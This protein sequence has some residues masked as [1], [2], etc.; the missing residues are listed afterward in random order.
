MSVRLSDC[1]LVSLSVRCV[2]HVYMWIFM[3]VCESIYF[4]LH[5][6]CYIICV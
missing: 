4:N 6:G 2:V 1:L 5:V 3:R